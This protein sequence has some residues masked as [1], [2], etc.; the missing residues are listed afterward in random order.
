VTDDVL[1][2]VRDLSVEYRG[3]GSINRAVNDVS[4]DV[5]AGEVVGIVGESGSGKSSTVLAVLGLTRQGGRIVKGSVR[6]EGRELLELSH[7]ELRRIR[8][9][10]IGLVVQNPRGALNPV[11]RVGEQIAG[12]YRAHTNAKPSQARERALELLRMVGINDPERRLEAFPHELSGG[13]AQRV[14]I[15]MSLACNP[16]LL[17]ADE[18]TSGLDVTVQAQLLDELRGAAD[19]AGSAILLVT[20]DLGIVANYCDRVYMMHAGEIVEHAPVV[21]FFDHPAHPST[22][23]LL[24]AQRKR[25]ADRLALRGFPIDGR[26]LPEGC[27]LHSRCPFASLDAGCTRVHP[28]LREVLP[29][30]EARCHRSD[31]VQAVAREAIVLNAEMVADGRT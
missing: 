29:G 31:L 30:H 21:N 3:V 1:L 11:V 9:G 16:T 14:L 28:E 24:A 26:R 5:N 4:F 23:A 18:P 19:T 15:A 27:Y 12:V 22:A 6:F 10:R 25:G 13:M 20:Q 7:D 8:G 17:I 2:R